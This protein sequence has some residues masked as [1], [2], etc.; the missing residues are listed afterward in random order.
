ME[1]D[2]KGNFNDDLRLFD[3]YLRMTI[4]SE[5]HGSLKEHKVVKVI[6][7]DFFHS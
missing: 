4:A 3:L 2:S 5:S 7:V 6:W 1:S